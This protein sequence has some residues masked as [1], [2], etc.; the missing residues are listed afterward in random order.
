MSVKR[1]VKYLPPDKMRRI[2]EDSLRDF[3]KYDMV[4][5]HVKASEMSL[6]HRVA[7]YIERRLPKWHVDCE[8]N[9]NLKLPK[10]RGRDRK[11]ILPDL[12]VHRRIST[13]NLLGIELK[14]T[15]HSRKHRNDAVTRAKELA[16]L[17]TKDMPQYCHA[18]VLTF[19]V[20]STELKDPKRNV[21]R[22]DWFHRHGCG[23]IGIGS[24]PPQEFHTEFPLVT[25]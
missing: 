19:P 2:V 15:S 20:R 4:L 6:A 22:C 12:I 11:K 25:S 13:I 3:A 18:V 16:G 5:L 24:P 17:R 1:Q 8:Y 10:T 9:R 14:K 7:V 21:V 23:T